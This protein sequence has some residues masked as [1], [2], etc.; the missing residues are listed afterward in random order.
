[1]SQEFYTN[2]AQW[3]NS[4][5]YRGIKNGRQVFLEEKFKPSLFIKTKNPS[6]WKSIYG[7]D[8]EEKKFQSISEAKDFLSKYKG[9]EGFEVHGME[10]FLYQYISHKFEEKIQYQ[11]NQFT[12]NYLDIE[13]VDIEN[14]GKSGFPDIATANFPVVLITCHF[15][16]RQSIVYG[17]KDYVTRKGDEFVYKS[18][19]S[20]EEMLNQFINDWQSHYPDIV[21]GWN[22]EG[23]DIPYLINRIVN[24]VGS[25]RAKKLSPWGILKERTIQSR[26]KEIDTFDILGITHI[27]YLEAYKKFGTYSGK[28]S[29]ALSFIAQEELGEDK[30]EMPGSSFYDNWENH[31]D[32]FVQYNYRDSLLVEKLDKKKKLFDTLISTAYLAKCNLEDVF[33]PANTWD[34]FIYNNLKK[35]FIVPPPKSHRPKGEFAGAYVKEPQKGLLGWLIYLDFSSLYPTIARQWN[36]S[37]ETLVEDF[38]SPVSFDLMLNNPEKAKELLQ[39]LYEK[40]YTIAANGSIY[41]KDIN[42]IIPQ[43]MEIAVD[44]RKK[45]KKE[46]LNKKK[47][48]EEIKTELIH[49]K[50]ITI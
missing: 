25:A 50:V 2:V 29:Y 27:D 33:G 40:N 37:P 7:D 10:K 6:V 28:E 24:T 44:D 36:I 11:L 5:L 39:E 42:G 9:V 19:D 8:L 26:G 35:D 43:M 22:T 13:V 46:M 4:I 1:M 18:F 17:L 21:S 3:G 47:L 41:R 20:E 48:Y 31:H 38:P 14:K 23:F 15:N 49:R 30:L 12:I 16:N 34:V 32:T 45:A